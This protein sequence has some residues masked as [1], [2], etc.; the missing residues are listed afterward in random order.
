VRERSACGGR[1]NGWREKRTSNRLAPRCFDDLLEKIRVGGELASREIGIDDLVGAVS[2]MWAVAFRK[3]VLLSNQDL[4]HGE[5]IRPMAGE[6]SSSWEL[7]EQAVTLV[8]GLL[9]Q[10]PCEGRKHCASIDTLVPLWTLHF[11]ALKRAADLNLTPAEKD[12]LQEQLISSL[13]VHVDHWLIRSECAERWLGISGRSLER[14]AT[15]L[16]ANVA[17]YSQAN[18]A[19]AIADVY[20]GQLRSYLKMV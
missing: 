4:L 12:E 8:T 19:K 3:G 11:S 9:L 16:T 7:I 15:S 17:A 14:Y 10:R 6:L 18:D 5:R 13:S 1:K 20:H 2:F